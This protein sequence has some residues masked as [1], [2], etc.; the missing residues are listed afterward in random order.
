MLCYNCGVD[1]GS[2]LGLCEDCKSARSEPSPRQPSHVVT[3]TSTE[4][5]FVE[6][7]REKLFM[8]LS[9][10]IGLMF[11]GLLVSIFSIPRVA[12]VSALETTSRFAADPCENKANCIVVYLAP[13]CPACKASVGTVK[14]LRA[15]YQS[16]SETGFKVI[17]G[18]SSAAKLIDFSEEIG[19]LVYM[20]T[21]GKFHRSAGVSAVPTIFLLDQENQIQ[22]TSRVIG[23]QDIEQVAGYLESNLGI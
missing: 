11:A 21:Q 15:Y 1:I 4:Q 9:V 8:G 19:G 16:E 5:S 17:V 12:D 20:D 10:F 6:K 13:W 7:Y 23:G 2:E 18:S 3:D 22:G 14:K